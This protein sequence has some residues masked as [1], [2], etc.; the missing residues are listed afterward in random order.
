MID[1]CHKVIWIHYHSIPVHNAWSKKIGYRHTRELVTCC[2]IAVFNAVVL[3]D[4]HNFRVLNN[5]QHR[6]AVQPLCHP[7]VV[8]FIYHLIFCNLLVIAFVHALMSASWIFYKL[9]AIL[10]YADKWKA[11]KLHWSTIS[12]FTI[13]FV[14]TLWFLDTGRH[15]DDV[16]SAAEPEWQKSWL[17]ANLTVQPIQFQARQ[18]DAVSIVSCA[19]EIVKTHLETSSSIKM[20]YFNLSS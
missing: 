16:K 2:S 3:H 7:A 15:L 17:I 18:M 10:I 1:L 8:A 4:F 13:W 9:A 12:L 19:S 20:D 14:K 11:I 5:M 6:S